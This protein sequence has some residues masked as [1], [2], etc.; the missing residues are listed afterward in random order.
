MDTLCLGLL[1]LGNSLRSIKRGSGQVFQTKEA[2]KMIL[3]C[4]LLGC[5]TITLFKTPI[6]NH[7]LYS[8][9]LPL[10]IGYFLGER[11]A[12]R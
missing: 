9:Y 12:L 11:R 2:F 5:F 8:V 4:I 1:Y 3:V 7:G 6:M 10:H